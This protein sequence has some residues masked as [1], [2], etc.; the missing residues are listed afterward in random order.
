MTPITH[1][2]AGMRAALPGVA[3]LPLVLAISGCF[4]GSSSSSDSDAP[5]PSPGQPAT[6]SGTFVD[7]AVVGLDY[8]GSETP[9]GL[10]DGQGQFTYR[11]GESITFS[12]GDLDLGT[13][14]GA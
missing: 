7:S 2:R 14:P 4:G 8:Q 3:L 9:A 13:A 6:L 12:I 10:T 1:N 5:A 11:E